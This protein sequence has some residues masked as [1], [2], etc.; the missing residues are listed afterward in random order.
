MAQQLKVP[1]SR[2]W[3]LT[4]NN[5][6]LHPAR[7]ARMH[8]FDFDENVRYLAF[9]YEVAPTTGTPHL[10]GVAVLWGDRTMDWMIQ[11]FPAGIHTEIMRDR[12]TN[13]HAYCGKDGNQ[14]FSFGEEPMKGRR[15]D[16][17]GF[18]RLLEDGKTVGEIVVEH[19]NHRETYVKYNR[20]LE[21]VA[22]YTEHLSFLVP[23]NAEG[24]HIQELDFDV[25]QLA[26]PS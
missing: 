18:T 7:E 9:S 20:G 13:A 22:A 8:N 19:E 1:K 3:T 4:F 16:I 14:I 11:Q 12:F 25:Q 26:E 10:Q 15:S 21:K 6:H 23:L 24:A 5:W 2:N 17:L